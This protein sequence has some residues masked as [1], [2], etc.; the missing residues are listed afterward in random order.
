MFVYFQTHQTVHIKY[1]QFF[2]YQLYLNKAVLKKKMI[3]RKKNE[4]EI[5]NICWTDNRNYPECFQTEKKKSELEFDKSM[6]ISAL[7][8]AVVL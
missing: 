8:T 1:G 4:S 2:V 3:R 6:K 7:K 5:E